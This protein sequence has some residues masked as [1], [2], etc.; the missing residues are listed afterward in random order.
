[1]QNEEAGSRPEG[2]P[3]SNKESPETGDRGK[4]GGSAAVVLI[5]PPQMWQ[6]RY[7]WRRFGAAY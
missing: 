1:M 3:C 2:L 6:E 7:P 5:G 4:A